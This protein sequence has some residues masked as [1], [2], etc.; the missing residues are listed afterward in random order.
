MTSNSNSGSISRNVNI[1][2]HM[3]Y[4]CIIYANS[5]HLGLPEG[6]LICLFNLACYLTLLCARVAS[7]AFLHIWRSF[8]DLYINMK[9]QIISVL[10]NYK[11]PKFSQSK[12]IEAWKHPFHAST[13]QSKPNKREKWAVLSVGP[14]NTLPWFMCTT[15]LIWIIKH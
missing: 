13:S 11:L 10:N 8:F 1:Q 12:L 3:F 6:Q 4:L 7:Q 15:L 5:Y 14:I 9:Y 2:Q